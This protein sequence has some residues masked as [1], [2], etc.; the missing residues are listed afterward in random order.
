MWT[1]VPREAFWWPQSPTVEFFLCV[2]SEYPRGKQGRSV[3]ARV[4]LRPALGVSILENTVSGETPIEQSCLSRAGKDGCNFTD[5][6][7]TVH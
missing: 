6:K 1:H 3:V 7:V 2:Q 5:G 4:H